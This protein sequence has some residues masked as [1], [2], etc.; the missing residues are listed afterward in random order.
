[1]A[2]R[3]KSAIGAAAAALGLAWCHG[4]EESAMHN[5]TV[6]RGVEGGVKAATGGKAIGRDLG[7]AASH[8]GTDRRAPETIIDRVSEHVPGLIRDSI[9]ESQK[10][11]QSAADPDTPGQ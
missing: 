10:S 4:A 9:R 5:P 2:M 3:T 11:E 8:D 7:T 1:M 6:V